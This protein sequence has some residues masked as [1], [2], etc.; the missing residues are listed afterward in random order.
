MGFLLYKIR[1]ELDVDLRSVIFFSYDVIH[2]KEGSQSSSSIPESRHHH[3]DHDS[4]ATSVPAS[5]SSTATPSSSTSH[6]VPMPP[7]ALISHKQMASSIESSMALIRTSIAAQ[8]DA[9]TPSPPLHAAQT[10]SAF[11]LQYPRCL[12]FF[13]IVVVIPVS[14]RPCLI[15]YSTCLELGEVCKEVGLP[16]GALNILTGL[17]QEAGAPLVSHP[18]VDKIA[19]TGSNATG[20]K[21]MTA[22]AQLVKPVTLAL[23]GKNPIVIFEDFSDLDKVNRN[24]LMPGIHGQVNLN[25]IHLHSPTT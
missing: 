14:H 13:V 3:D 19:F 10:P 20:L 21:I 23:G 18:H 22:A 17:G 25:Y 11:S 24:M 4:L 2:Q 6:A 1:N 7:P 9:A 5:G 8:Q 15:C 12:L 16:P